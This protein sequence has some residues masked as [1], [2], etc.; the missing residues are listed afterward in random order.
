MREATKA[1]IELLRQQPGA[2]HVM[3]ACRCGTTTLWHAKN[4]ALSAD[5]GYTGAR[6]IFATGPE[7]QC[8]A[9]DLYCVVED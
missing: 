5:G 9:T 1:E 8:P 4:L 2:P 3:F 6:N 7:C